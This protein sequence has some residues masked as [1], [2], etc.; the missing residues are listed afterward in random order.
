MGERRRAQQP[1]MSEDEK[2]ALIRDIYEGVVRELSKRTPDSHQEVQRVETEV[3]SQIAILEQRI[4]DLERSGN[5][6]LAVL[7]AALK[8]NRRAAQGLL[9]WAQRT[10]GGTRGPLSDMVKRLVG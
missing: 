5:S 10:Q 9:S 6:D 1:V 3:Q 8:E 4:F 2:M 7:T